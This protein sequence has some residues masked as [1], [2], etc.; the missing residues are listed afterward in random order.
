MKI[1]D[2]FVLFIIYQYVK[3]S[4]LN[5]FLKEW[6]EKAA[7]AKKDYE[8]SMKEYQAKRAEASDEE[9]EEESAK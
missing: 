8:K 9:G 5:L 1:G 3:L 2:I 6:N 7:E 4:Y